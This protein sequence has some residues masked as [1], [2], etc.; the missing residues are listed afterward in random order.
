MST[1]TISN[2]QVQLLQDEQVSAEQS[3]GHSGLTHSLTD[4]TSGHTA[5][6]ELGEANAHS[7]RLTCNSDDQGKNPNMYIHKKKGCAL[8]LALNLHNCLLDKR[9]NKHTKE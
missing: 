5:A 4:Q 6:V 1:H 2:S 9:I 7:Q 8:I 3:S